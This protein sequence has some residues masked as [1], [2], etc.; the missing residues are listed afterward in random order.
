MRHRHSEI[1]KQREM[2]VERIKHILEK[3]I[4]ACSHGVYDTLDWTKE[5]AE[6]VDPSLEYPAYYLAPHHG[7]AEGYLSNAQAMGWAFVERFF[8]L[9][10]VLPAFLT[11]AG[12]THPHTIVDLG[13]GIATSSI[14]LT[15]LFPDAQLTL[16]DLSPY[17][18]AA[19]RR[20]A[21]NAGLAERTT[22]RH[23]CA[24]ATGLP[25]ASADL[26]MSTL[27]FHELP[28][29][30]AHAVVAEAYRV[31]APGGR[32]VEFD[33]IQRVVPWL[34][35][36]RAINTLLAVLI[37]EVYWLEYMSQPVWDVCRDAGFEHVERKLLVAFPWVYQLVTAT[38]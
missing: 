17:Q 35:A 30:Q 6:Q 29:P 37:R 15:Q 23:A 19:A 36:D 13:C 8:R 27:L 5:A 10:R 21:H 31:L 4:V 32:F 38:K 2:M 1:Q 25:D 26:V 20:Q 12:A 3:R 16:L 18:L 9:H 33:P 11:I 14:V 22:Y 34:W 7:F 24:E 28:R